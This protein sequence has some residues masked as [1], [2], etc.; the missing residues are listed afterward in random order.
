MYMKIFEKTALEQTDLAQECRKYMVF[1]R[2]Y[3][4]YNL[5]TVLKQ[6]N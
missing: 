2:S 1:I 3:G 6:L 4:K 5:D